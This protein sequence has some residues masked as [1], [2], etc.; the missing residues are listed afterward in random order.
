TPGMNG[1]L[2]MAKGLVLVGGGEEEHYQTIGETELRPIIN[3][4]PTE[5]D[6]VKQIESR[7]L[8]HPD[9]LRQLSL[10]SVAYIRRHHDHIRIAQQFLQVWQ[11]ESNTVPP[12][13]D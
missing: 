5:D 13:E 11:S 9:D 12:S 10:D 7:L 1:L 3:V 4:C 2:A 6:V 8:A